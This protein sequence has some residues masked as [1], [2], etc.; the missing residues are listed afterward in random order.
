M[1]MRALTLVR[2]CSFIFFLCG[3]VCPNLSYGEELEA[4]RSAAEADIVGPTVL[5]YFENDLFY[6]ED[7][8]YTNAVQVRVVSPDLRVLAENGFLPQGISNMLGRVPF[9][10]SKNAMQYNI[11]GGLGQQIYTP[12]DT[13]SK[14]LQT[15]DRPYAGYLYGIFALHAKRYN[16]LDT[17]ELA[18]G[19]IGPSALG[20]QAQNEIHRLRSFDTAKGWKHQLRDEP[21][22]ML[23]WSRIWRLN[24]EA[25]PASWGWDVLP[26]FN[27][28]LG[29]PFT[30]AGLGTEMRL[31]WN[32]PSDYG[33]STIRPGAGILRPLKDEAANPN[34][35]AKS[36]GFI[37][38]LSVYAFAGAR[39]HAV[40]WNSFLDGNIWK[41]SHSVD[42]F[43]FSG[44]LYVGASVNIYRLFITYTH[45][46][47]SKE[48][49][50]QDNNGHHYGSISFGYVF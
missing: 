22:V 35:Y 46:F 39:G 32:L 43:P 8:D 28:S 38:N 12:K 1:S 20:E 36:D 6:N 34:R 21:A 47:E 17:F 45:A 11:S 10:G 24:H 50:G 23:T 30:R 42:K 16:R 37:D 44:E 49:H 29:T 33:T 40:A 9:P 4:Q 27:A 48:F 18:L 3:V 14:E 5:F 31:G 26:E 15:E 2:Y 41:D 7:R 19:M 25:R 13:D